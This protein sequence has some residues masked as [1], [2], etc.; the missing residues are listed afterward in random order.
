MKEELLLLHDIL[1]ST[2]MSDIEAD[3]HIARLLEEESFEYI[4]NL[5]NYFN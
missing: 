2:G 4:K 5:N 1:T 3:I